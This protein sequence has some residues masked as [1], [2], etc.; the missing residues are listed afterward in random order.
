MQ[1]HDDGEGILPEDIQTCG[2]ANHT[3]KMECQSQLHSHQLQTHG[4][5]G[6]ALAALSSFCIL[7]IISCSR[8]RPNQTS[9]TIVRN[10]QPQSS[11]SSHSAMPHPGTS[12][13]CRDL[14][15]NRPVIRKVRH[16][17]ARDS[18][19]FFFKNAWRAPNLICEFAANL[20]TSM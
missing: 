3:S 5:R 20:W 19:N 14:F 11:L 13:I 9:R 16:R 4:F 15:Y 8:F 12:I 7:E 17:T 1:V 2:V 10:G 6:Q 18:A